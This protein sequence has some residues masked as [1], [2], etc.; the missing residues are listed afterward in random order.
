MGGLRFLAYARRSKM[1]FAIFNL[2]NKFISTVEKEHNG[3]VVNIIIS[4]LLIATLLLLRSDELPKA[5]VRR[6]A[7]NIESAPTNSERR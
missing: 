5:G 6:K 1:Q 4:V 7:R 2:D 3:M